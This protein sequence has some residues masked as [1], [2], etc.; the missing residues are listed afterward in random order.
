MVRTYHGPGYNPGTVFMEFRLS[1][2]M[3]AYQGDFWTKGQCQLLDPSPQST[4][5]CPQSTFSCPQSTFSCPHRLKSEH[6]REGDVL[7]SPGL[8]WW[9]EELQQMYNRR[10][11]GLGRSRTVCGLPARLSR[12]SADSNNRNQL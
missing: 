5:S 9:R 11:Q 4:F 8:G 7:G 1:H 6:E 10:C 12:G 2:R 3:E